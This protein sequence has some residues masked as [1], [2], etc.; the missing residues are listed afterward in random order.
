[1]DETTIT[2]N[3]EEA[4]LFLEFRKYQSIWAKVFKIK[5]GKAVLHF[6]NGKIRKVEYNNQ[7]TLNKEV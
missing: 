6:G 3:N 2:L 1:M 4:K 5:T 7:E